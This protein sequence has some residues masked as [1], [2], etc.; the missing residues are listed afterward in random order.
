MIMECEAPHP[1]PS[2]TC[3]LLRQSFLHLHSRGSPS[4]SRRRPNITAPNGVLQSF[5]KT[6]LRLVPGTADSSKDR[7]IPVLARF[8]SS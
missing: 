5:I 8:T 2:R 1:D 3:P 7:I 4:L 6:V